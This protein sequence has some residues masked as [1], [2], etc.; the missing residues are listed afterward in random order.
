M[1]FERLQP[2][3]NAALRTKIGNGQTPELLRGNRRKAD[4]EI[5]SA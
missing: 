4:S 5:V 2:A 1:A 3:V